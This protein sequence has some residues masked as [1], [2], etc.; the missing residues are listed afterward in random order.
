[1][2]FPVPE[3]SRRLSIAVIILALL[4]LQACTY[5]EL[6]TDQ[7][8]RPAGEPPVEL[9]EPLPPNPCSGNLVEGYCD[10]IS[11]TPGEQMQVFLQS[12]SSIGLCK[13][14]IYGQDEKIAF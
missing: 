10:K 5:N 11:Y 3:G 9:V 13:L 1:M 4:I 12:K 8:T 6:P 14:D 7:R 2:I